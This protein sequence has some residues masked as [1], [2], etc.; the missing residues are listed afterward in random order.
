MV[1]GFGVARGF[2]VMGGFGVAGAPTREGD[3]AILP[4]PR[5]AVPNH[6]IYHRHPAPHL[7]RVCLPG[8]SDADS[9]GSPGSLTVWLEV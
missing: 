3:T 6:S 1:G 4:L 5:T 8:V 2:G 9:R 7:G